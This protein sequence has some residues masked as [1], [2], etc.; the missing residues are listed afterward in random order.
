MIQLLVIRLDAYSSYYKNDFSS[1]ACYHLIML[2]MSH[3]CL[4]F[5]LDAATEA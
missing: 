2:A 4:C 1:L 5:K 3:T